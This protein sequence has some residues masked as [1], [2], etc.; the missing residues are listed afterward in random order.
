MWNS[1]VSGEKPTTSNFGPPKLSSRTVAHLCFFDMYC[2]RSPGTR[3]LGGQVSCVYSHPVEELLRNPQHPYT[4]ALLAAIPDPDPANASRIREVPSGE[5][6][7]LLPPPSGCR[8]HPRCPKFMAG[9]RE[10]REP[11]IFEASPAHRVVRAGWHGWSIRSH[12]VAAGEAPDTR[13]R[14][15]VA[16]ARIVGTNG[17]A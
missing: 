11:Q 8:F 9:L 10:L 3:T 12:G 5:P 4:H 13:R 14:V 7:S 17:E 2:E 15:C 1:P 6:P 16:L